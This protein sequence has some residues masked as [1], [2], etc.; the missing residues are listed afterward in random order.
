MKK[1]LLS[2]SLLIA[3]FLVI[4]PIAPLTATTTVQTSITTNDTGTQ[5][6]STTERA[7]ANVES[8][9]TPEIERTKIQW[10]GS[11]TIAPSLNTTPK[12]VEPGAPTVRTAALSGNLIPNPSVEAAGSGG[13]PASWKKGGY[14]SNTRTLTYPVTGSSGSGIRVQ[15]SNYQAGDA[16]WYF[17]HIPIHAGTTYRFSDVYQSS[18][19]SIVTAQFQLANGS[20]YTRTSPRSRRLRHSHQ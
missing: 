10:Q 3:T 4:A 11:E 5:N 7:R 8:T 13:L 20:M 12:Q 17:T 9:R 6:N 18:V 2:L 19:P 16:K 1:T 15:V 14:G